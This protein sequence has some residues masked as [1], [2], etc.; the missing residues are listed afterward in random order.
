MGEVPH[1]M[2]VSF[3]REGEQGI[4]GSQGGLCVWGMALSSTVGSLEQRAQKDT[5]A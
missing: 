5:A 1:S 2:G 3:L 4:P